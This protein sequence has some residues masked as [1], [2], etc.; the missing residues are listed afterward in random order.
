MLSLQNQITEGTDR[1]S[2]APSVWG[3]PDWDAYFPMTQQTLKFHS[4]KFPVFEDTDSESEA[5]PAKKTELTASKSSNQNPASQQ[6]RRPACAAKPRIT[7]KI[8][9]YAEWLRRH[10]ARRS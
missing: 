10:E 2:R 6:Q 5:E 3:L 9:K 8:P 4:Y 7:I 1:A